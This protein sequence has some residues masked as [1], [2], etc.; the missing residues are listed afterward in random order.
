MSKE[1]FTFQS[2][3]GKTMLHAVRWVPQKINNPV[4][5]VQIIHGMCEH[6]GRYDDFAEY[7]N[8]KGFVV[9]AFDLLGHGSS[10]SDKR[11]GYFCRKDPATVLVK[12]VHRLKKI[13]E[14]LYPKIP[15][16]ILGHSIGS[17]ILRNYLFKYAKGIKGAIILGTGNESLLG[18]LKL[19]YISLAGMMLGKASQPADF[20]NKSVQGNYLKRVPGSKT[21]WDWLT[22]EDKAVDGFINDPKCG[23][24]F[25]YNGFYTLA[26]LLRRLHNKKG[27]ER[28]PVSLR[29]LIASGTD[30]PVG[31]Y[32][33]DPKKL[34]KDYRE[35]GMQHVD[36]M[37]YENDRHEILNESD[38]DKV[39]E[40]IYGWLIKKI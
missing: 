6:V 32:G 22:K 30:D 7:L 3:N 26:E 4:G 24:C 38:K 27:L 11:V 14:G 16:Y 18:A 39:Y 21:Q 15:Y 19:K 40:D 12:D 36:L 17:L 2:R 35:E 20:L 29:V 1:E 8:E 23:F 25:S 37:L 10:I 5:V 28:M 31:H 9:T 34:Y 33:I 13:T